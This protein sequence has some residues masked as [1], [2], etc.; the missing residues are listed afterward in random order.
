MGRLIEIATMQG[1]PPVLDVCI[2][3]LLVFNASGAHVLAGA[4]AVAL[5]G[6]FMKSVVGDSQQVLSPA[7]PPNAVVFLV[8]R[9]GLAKISIVTGSPWHGTKTTALELAI[10][11]AP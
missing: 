3:D 9:S 2:G 8:Q 4:E 1:L 10:T 6:S 11:V 5:L 7:G